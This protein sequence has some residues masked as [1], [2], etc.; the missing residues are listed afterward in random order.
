[1]LLDETLWVIC[2]AG[3]GVGKTHLA[4][5]LCEVLPGSVYAKLGHGSRSPEKHPNFFHGADAL[6]E[7]L[8][9]PADED[10]QY[11]HAVIEAN[12]AA[13][14]QDADVVIY[15]DGIPGH[16]DVRD[17]AG[18]MRES[19]DICINAEGPGDARA[20]LGGVLGDEQLVDGIMEIVNNHSDF[21]STGRFSVRTKVWF[22]IGGRRTFGP[23]LARLLDGV[24]QT[25]SLRASADAA[26][27]SYRH[28][29]DLVHAAE[30]RF[31]RRLLEG[32]P[33]GAGGG[34]SELTPAG[35]AMLRIFR[36]LNAQVARFADQQCDALYAEIME[37]H[38]DDSAG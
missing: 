26:G 3:R 9:N 24:E 4:D 10:A 12:D 18:Q 31:G 35:E 8:Q 28:A 7:F 20:V 29:W 22:E 6:A 33:G 1:M 17:D 14:R 2:G 5:R 36:R 11:T 25:G 21:L 23:G 15:I 37:D 16:T 30:D 13:L 27:M 38:T 34:G 32:R 19:A